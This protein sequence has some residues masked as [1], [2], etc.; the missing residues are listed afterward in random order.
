MRE[1][2]GIPT[3]FERRI[4]MREI[5]FRG[6]GLAPEGEATA[7]HFGKLLTTQNVDGKSKVFIQE[8]GD[9][10]LIKPETVGESA[11]VVDN[12]GEDIYEGDLVLTDGKVADVY[13]VEY[14]LFGFML[15]HFDADGSVDTMAALNFFKPERLTVVD[16]VIDRKDRLK[17]Q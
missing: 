14:S 13:V 6:K 2:T 17:W 4:L 5:K 12:Y 3:S 11:G 7:W 16:N 1:L 15:T 9:Y 10:Y 8:G